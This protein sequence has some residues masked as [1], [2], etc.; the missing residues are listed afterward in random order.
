MEILIGAWSFTYLILCVIEG[1]YY[2]R[3]MANSICKTLMQ[4][5]HKR[6]KRCLFSGGVVR[7]TL[8]NTLNNV[9][10]GFFDDKNKEFIIEGLKIA[11]NI[12]MKVICPQ[13]LYRSKVTDWVAFFEQY[14]NIAPFTSAIQNYK[15]HQKFNSTIML[16]KISELSDEQLIYRRLVKFYSEV[17]KLKERHF[18]IYPI[19]E[20]TFENIISVHGKCIKIKWMGCPIPSE[21]ILDN[22]SDS[23]VLNAINNFNLNI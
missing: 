2:V 14:E 15:K 16:S 17:S 9:T 6:I 4:D 21:T 22:I 10:N 3:Q 20:A 7:S 13:F 23:Y 12:I 18:S 1:G 5:Q 11:L 19:Q 8:I